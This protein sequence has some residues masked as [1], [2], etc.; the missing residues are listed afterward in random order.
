MRSTDDWQTGTS[1]NFESKPGQAD[2]PS[3]AASKALHV[4]VALTSA[5]GPQRVTDLAKQTGLAKATVYRMLQELVESG[6]AMTTAANT[7]R[8]GPRLIGIA[9]TVL[10]HDPHRPL[11]RTALEQ[12]RKA[13][14]LSSHFAQRFEDQVVVVDSAE[15]T[16]PYGLPSQTGNI[17]PIGS[18][19]FGAAIASAQPGASP[20][21]S[22]LDEADLRGVRSLAAPVFAGDE[23]VI[24]AIGV[25]G[26]AFN[27][28]DIAIDRLGPLVL[29]AA[30][31]STAVLGARLATGTNRKWA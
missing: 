4:L 2:S 7:Y 18:T 19:A 23:H 6:F 20:T 26:T 15:S 21:I 8:V 5:P 9:A 14:G 27:L 28:T 29:D 22:V 10:A 16:D 12:L 3:S 24:G 1:V 30:A 13:T 31:N 11:I 17:V 25:S